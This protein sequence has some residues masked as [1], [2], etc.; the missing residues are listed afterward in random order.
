M[1][2]HHDFKKLSTNLAQH[3]AKLSFRILY[4]IIMKFYVSREKRGKDIYF[5]NSTVV[6]GVETL[7]QGSLSKSITRIACGFT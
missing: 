6:K 7:V 5:R 3:P 1:K 2:F 4:K